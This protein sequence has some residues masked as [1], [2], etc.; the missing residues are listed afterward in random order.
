MAK[1]TLKKEGTTKKR[2]SVNNG[3]QQKLRTN[4][5][6]G[7]QNKTNST[8]NKT[9][10]DILPINQGGSPSAAET[11]LEPVITPPKPP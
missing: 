4:T 8:H 3:K 2:K 1:K 9:N 11:L 5:Q 10:I 7:T 6:S